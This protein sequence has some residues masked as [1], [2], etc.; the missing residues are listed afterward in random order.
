MNN[1]SLIPG[2]KK[3][4]AMAGWSLGGVLLYIRK[5]ETR[6]QFLG[7]FMAKL[8]TEFVQISANIALCHNMILR[9]FVL[10]FFNSL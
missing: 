1:T 9:I 3:L 6:I 2:P 8:L 7:V 5:K 4:P 10:L